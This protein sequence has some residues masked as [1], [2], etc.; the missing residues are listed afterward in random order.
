MAVGLSYLA[1]EHAPGTVWT[2]AANLTLLVLP[3]QR[4]V[5]GKEVFLRDDVWPAFGP[6]GVVAALDGVQVLQTFSREVAIA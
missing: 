2:A 5:L 6:G 4:K 3:L 1:A